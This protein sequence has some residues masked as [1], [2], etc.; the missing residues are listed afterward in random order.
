MVLELYSSTSAV[1]EYSITGCNPQRYRP[2]VVI[3]KGIVDI[4]RDEHLSR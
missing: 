4:I 3:P 2:C 1:L